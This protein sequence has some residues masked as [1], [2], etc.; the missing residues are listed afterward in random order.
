MGRRGDGKGGE[1]GEGWGRSPYLTPGVNISSAFFNSLNLSTCCK[2]GFIASNLALRDSLKGTAP[3]MALLVLRKGQISDHL[4]IHRPRGQD[5]VFIELKPTAHSR[6]TLKCIA[7]T[8]NANS[9]HACGTCL[10]CTCAKH[11]APPTH[12]ARQVRCGVSA[13]QAPLTA[14][15]TWG[16]TNSYWSNQHTTPLLYK[17]PLS[18]T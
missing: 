7:A 4:I 10:H 6:H 18:V 8:Y 5:S 16:P 13:Y 1:N 9:T 3:P 2:V 17:Q 12:P 14:S 11:A 15:S